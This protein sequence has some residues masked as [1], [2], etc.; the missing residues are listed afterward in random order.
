MALEKACLQHLL[1][2]MSPS[3]HLVPTCGALLNKKILDCIA[4][5][6]TDIQTNRV[7]KAKVE[8]KLRGMVNNHWLNLNIRFASSTDKVAVDTVEDMHWWY[9][10]LI[11]HLTPKIMREKNFR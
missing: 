4:I 11:T 6:V 10:L 2:A 3:S 5:P 8:G 7:T 1:S 9:H